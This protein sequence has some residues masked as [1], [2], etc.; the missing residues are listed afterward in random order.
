MNKLTPK[1]KLLAASGALLAVFALATTQ[2]VSASSLA[3]VVIG[4]G[5]VAG[6]VVWF[7][8]N[9]GG[10]ARVAAVAPRLQVVAR[11]GLSQRAGVALLEVDGKPFIVVHGDGYAQVHPTSP[12]ADAPVKAPSF[13]ELMAKEVTP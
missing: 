10:T 2:G 7:V 8:R 4:L 12:A 11:T 3:R 1:Q 9:R 5:A 6:M 13:R